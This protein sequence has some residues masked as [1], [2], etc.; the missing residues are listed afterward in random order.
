M[1]CSACHMEMCNKTGEI[2]LRVNS[3]LFIIR[4]ISYEECTACGEKILGAKA[5]Q[6]VYDDIKNRKFTEETIKIP[7]LDGTEWSR[8][9]GNNPGLNERL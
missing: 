2:D 7:V 6:H 5:A 3:R 1:K 8:Q 4:N 9:K